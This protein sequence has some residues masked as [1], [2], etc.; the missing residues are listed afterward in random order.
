[1]VQLFF[2]RNVLFVTQ[3]TK[4]HFTHILLLYWLRYLLVVNEENMQQIKLFQSV[5][6]WVDWILWV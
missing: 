3:Q 1:M 5:V 4:A 6:H 2:L